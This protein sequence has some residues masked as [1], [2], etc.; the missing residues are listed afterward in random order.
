MRLFA[1]VAFTLVC[2]GCSTQP[3][4]SPL[5]LHNDPGGDVDWRQRHVSAL[6]RSGM[7]V[8]IDGF[9]ASACTLY[10]YLPTHQ[11]CVT[12][13]SEL[14]FHDVRRMGP[15]NPI[16]AAYTDA[17]YRRYPA[18]VQQWL[19]SVGAYPGSGREFIMRGSDLVGRV[20]LCK[21]RSPSIIGRRS[22]AAYTA[23]H[24]PRSYVG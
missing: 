1:I 7:H 8:V 14:L 16:D 2:L 10:L 23:D 24:E 11:V 19:A 12:A 5:V 22:R 18:A 21:S 6:R 17:L 13:R 3:K 4:A 15:G 9:C 20:P